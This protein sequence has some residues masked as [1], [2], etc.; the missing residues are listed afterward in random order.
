MKHICSFKLF[1]GGDPEAK[2]ALKQKFRDL[3]NK[4]DDIADKRSEIALKLRGE[5]D[6]IKAEIITLELQ[7]AELQRSMAAID[8]K[9]TSRKY[10]LENNK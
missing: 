1:E 5:E 8:M 4:K 6:P 7:K 2:S 3:S 9:I 10:Q